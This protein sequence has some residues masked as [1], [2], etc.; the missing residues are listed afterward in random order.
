MNLKTVKA[1]LMKED[2]QQFWEYR[3]A[4]WAGK[5]LDAWCRRVQRT[6]IEPFKKQARSLSQHRP[7][8]LNWF[9][10]KGEYS[11]GVVEGFNNKAKT[12][13]KIAYGYRRVET[14]EV[15]LYH[16]LGRL[17]VPQVT[18]RFF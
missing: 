2:F 14:L 4:G 11:C 3:S 15:A 8:L 1:Y 6:R 13:I 18:H 7:L 9:K 16:T 10:A 12:M 5:F 17:P